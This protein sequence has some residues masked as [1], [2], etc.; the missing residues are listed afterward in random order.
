MLRKHYLKENS[1]VQTSLAAVLEM[2]NKQKL[3]IAQVIIVALL[4]VAMIVSLFGCS[5]A[6]AS[7]NGNSTEDEAPA[8]TSP[9]TIVWYPNES[10][11]DF[12]ESR[13]EIGRLIEQAT[14]RPVV[15]KLTTDYVI[16]I[17]SIA[18]G[19]ADIAMAMGA[20]GYIQ[21]QSRNPEV[22][23]LFVNSGESGTLDDAIYYSWLAV[24]AEDADQYKDGSSYSLKNI[25]G[26]TISFVSNSSTSG[27]KV[28]TSNIID[29][30]ASD[31][32]T[33]DDLVEG[34]S[35]AFFSEVLFG[36]SHQ[37]SAFNLLSGNADV[38]A[39]CDTEL[40]IYVELKKGTENTVGAV[41]AIKANASAPF[42]T[43]TGNEFV[44]ISSTPVLNGPNAYNPKNL[45][46]E[47]V[48]AIRDLFTSAE[49]SNNPLIF[50]DPSIEGAMGFYKKTASRGYVLVD[51]SWYDPLRNMN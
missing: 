1:I 22:G 14:G 16:A 11:N 5:A 45:S 6:T 20:T 18:S 41:Y 2:D 25:K 48:Q 13:A 8:N 38:A 9:I 40:Q 36:G 24:R 21:A 17:E 23:V 43:V 44:V 28:P 12:E 4:A 37:G 10:A 35:D 31:K 42:D 27:F 39:F 26:Q 47:E 51:D 7:N 29:Y 15:Q 30:F 49:V 33:T 32:L 19:S 50:Y 34:G 46:E 3:Q